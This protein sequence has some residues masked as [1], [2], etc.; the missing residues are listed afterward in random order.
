MVT[1]VMVFSQYNATHIKFI[2]LIVMKQS[3]YRCYFRV[4]CKSIE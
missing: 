1:L 4:T 3:N 2:T